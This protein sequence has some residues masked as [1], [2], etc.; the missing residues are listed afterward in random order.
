[1][2]LNYLQC[3]C[4]VMVWQRPRCS[5]RMH[6]PIMPL[7]DD[8]LSTTSSKITLVNHAQYISLGNYAQYDKMS[9][10]CQAVAPHI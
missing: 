7:D 1:M 3:A 6:D 2:A 8:R 4:M 10:L 9:A 5:K